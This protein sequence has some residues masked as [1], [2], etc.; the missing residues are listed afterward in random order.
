MALLLLQVFF[1]ELSFSDQIGNVGLVHFHKATD[2][3]HA[4]SKILLELQMLLV[5]PCLRQCA[6]LAPN[7]SR[8][9]VE[10]FIES[11]Q[12][13]GKPAQFCRVYN[14]LSH[15]EILVLK[16]SIRLHVE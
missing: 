13:L 6:H 11:P 16:G 2:G 9:I 8:F 3:F 15:Q 5:S 7:G 1:D 14:C 4:L 12:C 10:F